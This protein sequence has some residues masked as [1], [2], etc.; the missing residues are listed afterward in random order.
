MVKKLA[1]IFIALSIFMFS[2][3]AFAQTSGLTLDVPLSFNFEGDVTGSAENVG[4]FMLSIAFPFNVGIGYETIVANG[5][6]ETDKVLIKANYTFTD[7]YLHMMAGSMNWMFGY[8]TG[9]A[10]AE[11]SGYAP[12]TGGLFELEGKATKMFVGLGLQLGSGDNDV[13]FI[14]HA[15]T[16]EELL[17]AQDNPVDLSGNM[18]SIGFKVGL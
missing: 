12:G 17:D 10:K 15:I 16:A 14:Y 6:D 5:K 18:A 8:G 13:H 1:G 7:I 9:T 3:T 11:V 2:H 4:G